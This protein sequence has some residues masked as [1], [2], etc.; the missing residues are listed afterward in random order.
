MALAFIMRAMV[1][2]QHARQ[3]L[4][5]CYGLVLT[6]QMNVLCPQ[7][8]EGKP[9]LVKLCPT[10]ETGFPTTNNGRWYYLNHT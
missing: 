5:C 1:K 2:V 3:T 9:C 8:P 4:I 7:C 10:K 6:Y